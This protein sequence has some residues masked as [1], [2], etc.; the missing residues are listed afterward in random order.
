MVFYLIGLG[1]GDFYDITERGLNAI[2][3]CSK[4]YLEAY[5]SILCYG[6]DKTRLEEHC[7]REIIEADREFVETN[8]D[9]T[10]YLN[11][12]LDSLME[13]ALN[14]DIALLVVGDPFGATT[15]AEFILRAKKI[16]V[17]IQVIHNA[18]IITAVACCGLQVSY[19]LK[20]FIKIDLFIWG[21]CFDCYVDRRLVS[22]F[23]L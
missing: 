14:E 19:I 6:L 20:F 4:V 8:G 2:R 21:N 9:L 1:L 7:K 23:L 5:T 10:K 3:K 15:H 18:S 16:G 17:Q 22:G 11:I 13:S 12:Y